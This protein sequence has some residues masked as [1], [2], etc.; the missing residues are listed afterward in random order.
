MRGTVVL[1]ELQRGLWSDGDVRFEY[2]DR[3]VE[4]R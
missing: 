1:S 2:V 4:A 3:R